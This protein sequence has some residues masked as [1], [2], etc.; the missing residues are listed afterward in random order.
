MSR[1]RLP[2]ATALAALA[3][4]SAG[5]GAT[6]GGGDE[7]AA[8]AAATPFRLAARRVLP[9]ELRPP[10]RRAPARALPAAPEAAP[11]R[12]APARIRGIYVNAGAAGSPERLRGLLALADST[13]L[14]TFVVDVK[15]GAG[16]CFHSGVPLA[17]ELVRGRHLPLADAGALVD[18]LHAHGIYAVARIVTFKDPSLSRARPAWSIRRPDGSLWVDKA[19]NTWVS[20]WDR[21]VWDYNL[22]IAAAAARLGFDAIQFD[23]V[24]FPEPY[25]SLGPQVH[26]GEA[27]ERTDAVAGFL[28]EARRRLAPLGVEVAADVFGMSADDATDVGIGQ[29]WER[30]SQVVDQILPMVYP[31]HYLPTHLPGVPRPNRMPYATVRTA[32]GMGVIRNRRLAEAGGSPARV[33]PWLQAFDAPWVDRDFPYG[34]EQAR[35]QMRAVYDDG[36]DDWIFWNARSDYRAVA[37]AFARRN[38]PRAVAYQPPHALLH[39]MDRYEDWG[40]RRSRSRALARTA[41]TDADSLARATE[42]IAGD[43]SR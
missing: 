19:G 15:T 27:G 40:M 42:E 36:L 1:S 37:A 21:R 10:G 31:S 5:C 13:E 3:L 22:A 30:L 23:Y 16:E 34:P 2:L 28:A 8:P 25:A 6:P 43:R 9:P 32:V 38:E 26:P 41:D 18:T 4:L 20:A 35:A 24:R 14:N 29:Q 7:A 39:R 33:V 17:D 12:P 11:R